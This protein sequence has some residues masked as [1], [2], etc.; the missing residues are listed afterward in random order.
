MA[1]KIGRTIS[2][3]DESVT[4]T[5]TINSTTATLLLAANPER[6][7]ARISLDSGN[8]KVE[9][10][11]REYAAA[12]DNTKRGELMVRDTGSNHTLYKPTWFTLTD[13]VYTGEISAIAESGSFDLHITEG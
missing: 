3:T 5:V 10:F 11:I 9:A 8:S 6:M 4:T 2:T 12:T 13:N 1:K 7:Y